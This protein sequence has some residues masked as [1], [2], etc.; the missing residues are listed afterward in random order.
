MTQTEM[1]RGLALHFAELEDLWRWHRITMS[2][3]R[4]RALV[5]WQGESFAVSTGELTA[6]I[7]RRVELQAK[8]A[9]R[10][11]AAQATGQSRLW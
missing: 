10:L 5:T 7:M 3:R 6:A 8:G 11:A 9:T 1:V 4:R 2:R